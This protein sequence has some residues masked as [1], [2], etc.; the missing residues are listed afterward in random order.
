MALL[1]NSKRKFREDTTRALI[2]SYNFFADIRDL[3]ILSGLHTTILMFTLSGVFSLLLTILLT[4]LQ[5]NILLEKILLSF[6]SKW[7]VTS[8][9]FLAWHPLQSFFYLF[10][11]SVG[12]IFLQT[13]I[14]KL[15]S[16]FLKTRVLTT[17]IFFTVVWA[18]LPLALMIPF[19]LVLHRLL[20]AEIGNIFIYVFI[21]IYLMWLVQ[22]ILK[23]VYVIFDIRL[24]TVYFYT[25]SLFILVCG[26]VILYFQLSDSTIY[27]IISAFKQYRFV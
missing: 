7:F 5:N 17:N 2:R 6:N 8:V 16:F 19:E 24:A 18:L 21:L 26:I 1:I 10:A 25:F 3:R 27:Y 13:V 15:F 12:L 20:L 22:R 11:F 23:G 9:S 14:L 4:Y